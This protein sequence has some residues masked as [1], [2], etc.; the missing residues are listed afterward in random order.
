MGKRTKQFLAVIGTQT[1]CLAV[2]LWM[3]HHFA[4]A[5]TEHRVRGQ[6]WSD[7]EEGSSE[8][9]RELDGITFNDV[10]PA[11]PE[12][13]RLARILDSIRPSASRA[14]LVDADWHPVVFGLS[15]TGDASGGHDPGST[16]SVEDPIGWKL[17]ADSTSDQVRNFRGTVIW[18]LWSIWQ[19]PARSSA[20]AGTS[21]FIA[22]WQTWLPW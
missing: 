7:M 20:A 9:V 16:L 15:D 18:G 19:P 14:M 5:S 11:S 22:R 3:H 13:L 12:Y 4:I 1:L 17:R 6:M 8:A 2:G 21:W 10:T